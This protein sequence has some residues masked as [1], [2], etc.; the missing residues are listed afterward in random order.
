MMMTMITV[1]L[2]VMMTMTSEC[3]LCA[4]ERQCKSD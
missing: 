3:S 2:M 4:V 1:T